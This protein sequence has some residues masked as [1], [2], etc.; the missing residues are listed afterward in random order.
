MILLQ[1]AAGRKNTSM[2]PAEIARAL[3]HGILTVGRRR[4]PGET[5]NKLDGLADTSAMCSIYTL[6]IMMS[7]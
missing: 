4:I 1:D 2:F 7:Y 5:H 3:L 6:S